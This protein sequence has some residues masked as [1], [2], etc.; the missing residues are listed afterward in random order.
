MSGAEKP[1]QKPVPETK[2]QNHKMINAGYFIQEDQGKELA[3]L[4]IDFYKNNTA[5]PYKIYTRI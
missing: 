5:K 3:K 2:E 4:I 1:F